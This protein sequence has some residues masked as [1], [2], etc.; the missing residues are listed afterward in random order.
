MLM[1]EL[2]QGFGAGRAIVR[3]E[4]TAADT[5]AEILVNGHGGGDPRAR[6]REA[7]PPHEVQP[8][9]PPPPPLDLQFIRSFAVSAVRPRT[10]TTVD[11]L[12]GD[13]RAWEPEPPLPA[14]QS[15]TDVVRTRLPTRL[16]M[17]RPNSYPAVFSFGG[18]SAASDP[19][20]SR[21]GSFGV[22][23]AGEQG[24]AGGLRVRARLVADTGVAGWI[25]WSSL[26]ARFL[27]FSTREA[28]VER[29]AEVV[30]RYVDGDYGVE[31]ESDLE[32][33]ME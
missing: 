14:R 33:E 3:A 17:P 26:K 8:P 2:E 31:E 25:R 1:G 11:V 30:D 5:Q 32:D 28:V 24:M 16:Q 18:A 6:D 9:P 23:A 4:M 15:P 7:T 20:P 10:F 27:E 21:A 13:E 29:L 19:P 12:R 22:G